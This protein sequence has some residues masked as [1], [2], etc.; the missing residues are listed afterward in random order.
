MIGRS[1]GSPGTDSPMTP[2][3]RGEIPI[4]SDYPLDVS[5]RTGSTRTL[6]VRARF[7]VVSLSPP[8]PN[9]VYSTNCFHNHQWQR[10]G[11]GVRVSKEFDSYRSY[12]TC[13]SL[14]AVP[15]SSAGSLSG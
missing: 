14:S 13:A 9:P 3:T 1:N 5:I 4:F 7:R 6:N 15:T 10:T 2:L 8:L 11:S 12:P